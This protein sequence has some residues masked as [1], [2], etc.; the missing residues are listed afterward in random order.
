MAF[1]YD[2]T[3][4]AFNFVPEGMETRTRINPDL[5]GIG[6]VNKP[7]PAGRDYFRTPTQE[8]SLE[9]RHREDIARAEEKE[10]AA[11]ERGIGILE[12]VKDTLG[13]R[14]ASALRAIDQSRARTDALFDP[15]KSQY[16]ELFDKPTISEEQQRGL[17]GNIQKP[18]RR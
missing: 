3:T 8:P 12:D 16:S 10:T 15:V 13:S 17:V 6:N 14:L 4:G 18:T 1:Q 9:E 5:I 7:F 11:R 2:I